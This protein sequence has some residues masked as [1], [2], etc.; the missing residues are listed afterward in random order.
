MSSSPRSSLVA[1]ACK[2][3]EGSIVIDIRL[4]VHYTLKIL[5]GK[6]L[7]VG[8]L[9]VVV[10]IAIVVEFPCGVWGFGRGG[11]GGICFGGVLMATA[12]K[13]QE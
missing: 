3:H 10:D 7:L 2:L 4:Y 11:I 13:A 1:A 8:R 5:G 6:W 12:L 9:I